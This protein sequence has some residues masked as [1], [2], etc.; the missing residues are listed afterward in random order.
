[1]GTREI[2]HLQLDEIEGKN[3]LATFGPNATDHLRR[4][5]SFANRIFA[6]SIFVILTGTLVYAWIKRWSLLDNLYA[7]VITVTTV[8]YGDTSWRTPLGRLSQRKNGH[9]KRC[10]AFADSSISMKRGKLHV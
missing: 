6:A 3:P 2:Y 9:S 7:K 10:R 1:M 4:S 5:D 8:D